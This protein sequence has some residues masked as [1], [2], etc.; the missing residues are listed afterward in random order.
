MKGF[1]LFLF[2]KRWMKGSSGTQALDV[3]RHV[4]KSTSLSEKGGKSRA[5]GMCD[6]N[7]RNSQVDLW[8]RKGSLEYESLE[9]YILEQCHFNHK[10]HVSSTT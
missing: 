9:L 6:P 8:E 1:V 7:C 2:F 5:V 4:L 10:I 3:L